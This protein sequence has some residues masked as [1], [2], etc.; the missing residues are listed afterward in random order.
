MCTEIIGKYD[1]H[2]NVY[3]PKATN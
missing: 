3:S 2:I 1:I